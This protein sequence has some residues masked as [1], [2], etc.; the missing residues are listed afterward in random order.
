MMRKKWIMVV[1]MEAWCWHLDSRGEVWR[2]RQET[3]VEVLCILGLHLMS[4]IEFLT[5]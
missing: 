1:L 2:F 4:F 5:I 3:F